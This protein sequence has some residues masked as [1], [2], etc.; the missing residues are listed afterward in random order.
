[1]KKI[2]IIALCTL[3]MLVFII[4]YTLDFPSWQ[5]LDLKKIVNAN[6][7]SILYDKDG[8]E[9]GAV[10]QSSNPSFLKNEEI[11]QYVKNAFIA[12]EDK[13]F[14]SH[15]GVDVKRIFGA[16]INNLKSASYEEGGSTITQQLVKLTHLT[17][18]KKLSRKANEAVLAVK[19]EKKL[20]KDDILT[21][22]LNTVY[23]GSG[24]YGI[25][26]AGLKYFG[27]HTNELTVSEAATLAGIIKAPSS[28]SPNANPEKAEE[29]R[30][31]V[32]TRMLEDGYI[33]KDEMEKAKKEKIQVKDGGKEDAGLWY[34][35]L[36][37]K[38]AEKTLDLSADEILT[39]G[40]KI[41]TCL[42]KERQKRIEEIYEDKSLFP[43]NALNGEKAESAFICVDS[44]TGGI[45]CV[46]GGREYEVR[47][48]FNRATE[49]RRQPGSAL[50]PLSV[51]AAAVDGLGMSP[52][53][54]IDDTKRTFEGGYTPRNAADSY[55]GLVTMRE[56]LSKSL[57][58]AS[59]S[60]M[61]FTG[62]DRARDYIK[63]FGIPIEKSDSGLALALGSMTKGVT[64]KELTEGYA[65]LSNGG[66]AV[67]AH[68]IQ[69]I[70]D[71]NGKIV[72]AFAPANKRAVTSE[73]AYLLTSMLKTA[74]ATGS[75]RALKEVSCPVAAKTGTVSI[76]ENKNRDAW[77]AAY[78][79]EIAACIWM[80]FDET[81][82]DQYLASY[83]SG[84]FA[85]K[86]MTEFMKYEKAQEFEKPDSIVELLIDKHALKTQNRV[87]LAPEN[88]PVSLTQTEVFLKGHEPN[89]IS[90]AFQ[91]PSRP[92][93]PS[94]FE[95]GDET[96][97]RIR[98]EDP[99]N[100]YLLFE[101][102]KGNKKLIASVTG[103]MDE[104]KEIRIK[105]SAE[106]AVYTVAVRN[107]IMH[108]AGV[109][110]VSYESEGVEVPGKKTFTG[111][112]E[113][114]LSGF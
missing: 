20:S 99:S 13:R 83:E 15:S 9:L 108:E 6:A 11:P 90:P 89:V 36:V 21:A 109:T 107:K 57:N 91:T 40:F 65:A 3:C 1:M 28:Y 78:T 106:T 70:I 33:S 4:I 104:E 46:I 81:T 25:E 105:R 29:R 62:I 2:K 34:R 16:F 68:A 53:N 64:P 10:G 19:L 37:L 49:A 114:F 7:A 98:I 66:W 85:A 56:A 87:W 38:E 12:C 47:R 17:Q 42:D 100:E 58:V 79:T 41:Y 97:F 44:H 61:E 96:I 54:I 71:R 110:L 60:L 72:Y 88:A 94:V 27:K 30:N 113:N 14:Y 39:G 23:F 63:R 101:E 95:K 35:D 77:T 59:V 75:A 112:F 55:N 84:S 74:A 18:E 82:S 5:K 76:D 48:G 111:L 50:K 73:S 31:Y 80:G 52:S 32:L 43:K 8:N 93:A 86:L 92:D 24:A 67:K 102:I 22:Y 69:K 45:L 26:N 51:Y 103:K